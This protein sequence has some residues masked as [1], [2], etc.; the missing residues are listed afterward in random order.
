MPNSSGYKPR[1]TSPVLTMPSD[2]LAASALDETYV[3]VPSPRSAQ[4]AKYADRK[5]ATRTQVSTADRGP[6][7]GSP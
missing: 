3:H 5:E 7:S 1:D 4:V 6:K 2:A